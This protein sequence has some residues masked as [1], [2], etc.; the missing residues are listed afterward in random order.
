MSLDVSM[1]DRDKNKGAV[2]LLDMPEFTTRRESLSCFNPRHLNTTAR[3]ISDFPGMKYFPVALPYNTIEIIFSLCIVV[4]FLN[5]Q[6]KVRVK[7]EVISPTLDDTSKIYI[8]GNVDEL[9]GWNP[10]KIILEYNGTKIWSRK[11]EIAKGTRLEY[12]FTKGSWA[13]EALGS[14]SS[15]PQNSVFVANRDTTVSVTIFNWRDKFNM[16]VLCY[17]CCNKL[18]QSCWR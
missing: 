9:G 6:E 15:V 4:T 13:T 14:D 5:A 3:F 16:G 11:F 17:I 7:L 2:I 18:Y 10:G 12:K 1:R 8:A